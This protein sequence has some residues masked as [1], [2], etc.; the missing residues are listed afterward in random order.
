MV[1]VVVRDVAA[2]ELLDDALALQALDLVDDLAISAIDQECRARA[3][4]DQAG[5]GDREDPTRQFFLDSVGDRHP[6]DRRGAENTRSHG[7]YFVVA[8]IPAQSV[9]GEVA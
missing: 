3:R 9:D 5:V 8:T 6:L 4:D 2:V 1:V 7:A